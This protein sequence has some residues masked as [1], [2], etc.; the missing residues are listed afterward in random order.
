MPIYTPVPTPVLLLTVLVL[1]APS[2][3]AQTAGP[4]R[5]D[6]ASELAAEAIITEWLG[7]RTTSPQLVA[8]YRTLAQ[9]GCNQGQGMSGVEYGNCAAVILALAEED[10]A[11]AA[12]EYEARIDRLSDY[13]GEP[14]ATHLEGEWRTLWTYSQ[15]HWRESRDADCVSIGISA[16][17]GSGTGIGIMQCMAERTR[18]RTQQVRGM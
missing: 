15:R 7:D 4:G 17:G 5:A 11:A 6:P 10:L 1:S 2:C 13:V 12:R 9:R 18:E 8:Q 14:N 3:S 16:G